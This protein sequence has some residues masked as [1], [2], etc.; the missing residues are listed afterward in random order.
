MAID[1][2]LLL[3]A[4]AA[5]TL[6]FAW[7]L[8]RAGRVRL[9]RGLA[10]RSVADAAGRLK[11][12]LT[13][14]AGTLRAEGHLHG[15]AVILEAHAPYAG[16][17]TATVTV[18]GRLPPG[19]TIR[20]ETLKSRLGAALA[21]PDPAL[22][23]PAFDEAVRL[24]PG[25]HLHDLVSRLGAD[26]R[27]ALRR[28]VTRATLTT[29]RGELVAT[30]TVPD[31][32]DA[33][34]L[35]ALVRDLVTLAELTDDDRTTADRLAHRIATDPAPGYRLRCFALATCLPDS[36]SAR[37]LAASALEH[38]D[39]ELRVAAARVS[40]DDHSATVL[41][42][43][44]RRPDVTTPT[45]V[46]ALAALADLARPPEIALLREHLGA[47]DPSVRA[48]AA[49]CLGQLRDP[50]ALAALRIAL[51]DPAVPVQIAVLEA[52]GA[53]APVALVGEI[54]V[55]VNAPPRDAAVL[56]AARDAVAAIQARTGA[57]AGQLSLVA[58]SPHGALTLVPAPDAVDDALGAALRAEADAAEAG[59]DDLTAAERELHAPFASTKE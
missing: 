35:V 51:D 37:A 48:A 45:R 6:L 14:S 3:P 25:E 54:L 28:V 22:G 31:T 52:L 46:A 17:S 29:R 53:C 19:W 49:R 4:I 47:R 55:S 38:A 44:L 10:H 36:P 9:R 39:P 33:I 15:R 18:P 20:P 41:A 16:T 56:R 42:D 50:S 23:D 43:V 59:R 12:T 1:L 30:R 5:G 27:A 34:P 2:E 32:T 58:P 40:R 57:T 13:R 26:A 21:G 24:D 11:L 7:V 8:T